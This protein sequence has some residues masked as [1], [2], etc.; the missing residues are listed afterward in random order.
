MADRG[1]MNEA[2]IICEVPVELIFTD[3]DVKSSQ[4]EHLIE[5]FTETWYE[6][7]LQYSNIS[8][9]R[10]EP[11]RELYRYFLGQSASAGAYLDWY[12]KI[13]TTRGLEPPMSS[14]EILHQRKMEFINMKN[15]LSNQSSFFS[16]HPIHASYNPSGYFNIKDGHHRALFLYCCGFRRL[17][18]AMSKEN[19]EQWMN[20]EQA[21][22][23]QE[24]VQTQKRQL[25]YT[26]ILNPAFYSWRS[27]RDEIYPTRLD[28]MLRY[29][30]PY[31]LHELRILDIG[32]NIGYHAR[33]LTREGAEV[34]GIEH[35]PNHFQLLQ[36]LNRL[37]RTHFRWIP[38][39]FETT[40]TER[41]D[42]GIM[43]TVF[44]HVMKDEKVCG[45][46]LSKLNASISHLLFWESGDEIDAEKKLLMDNTDFTYY[47]KLADTF[48]TGKYREL[49][50]FLK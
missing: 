16:E 28:Y 7:H 24:T 48:G 29:L 35:D 17:Y 21:A 36:E 23:V 18:M 27:E 12:S 32:C 3:I 2:S 44:Y 37:E 42:I 25:I 39:P 22:V 47:E 11:H 40:E 26:P 43:L 46:F 38:E 10:F 14:E 15:E 33:C 31:H 34:T 20:K 45:T 49:G 30:G 5:Q 4:T 6:H 13:H 50:V 9:I 19:Y 8:I 1:E 41:Y